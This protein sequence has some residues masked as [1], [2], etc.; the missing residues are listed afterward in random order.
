[1][2]ARRKTKIA[3]LMGPGALAFGDYYNQMILRGLVSATGQLGVSFDV[4]VSPTADRVQ[5]D[6]KG[7]C[8]LKQ[9]AGILTAG[10]EMQGPT[11]A[12]A[13]QFPNQ[14]FALIDGSVD[15]MANVISYASN[16]REISFLCGQVVMKLGDSDATGC[17]LWSDNWVARE[18]INSF[19]MGAKTVRPEARVYFSFA[20]N[21]DDARTKATLQ[22][23]K[24]VGIIMCHAGSADLG[25]IKAA[26]ENKRYA[27]GFL[28][29]RKVD[30]DYVLFD[31]VRNLE[32]II[33][34]A[35]RRMS[36]PNF[37][38]D[39]LIKMGLKEGSF[40]LDLANAH[41]SI[42]RG[43]KRMIEMSQRQIARGEFDATLRKL[44]NSG[45]GSPGGILL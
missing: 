39:R 14:R 27:L 31:V 33:V 8:R 44:D 19:V 36:S 6:L 38:A 41:E 5:Q 35:A 16:P 24:G 1:M 20:N 26:K 22:F 3:A 25:I 40:G 23:T 2:P 43:E 45:A 32:P 12:C 18:W 21:L 42:G 30:P 13:K 37:D 9:Y 7:C 29:E 11:A 28:D 17:V 4:V 10:N 34:D 15:R